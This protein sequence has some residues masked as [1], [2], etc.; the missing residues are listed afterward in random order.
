LILVSLWLAVTPARDAG[1]AA[2]QQ[3]AAAQQGGATQQGGAA[4]PSAATQ[5][6]GTQ[7][8]LQVTL[9]DLSNINPSVQARLRDAHA[10]LMKEL[11]RLPASPV[12]VAN[13]YGEMGK[14]FMATR[15]N[16]EAERC[17]R[18]AQR[19]A[20]R[21]FAWPYYLGH[22]LRNA[23]DL[24]GAV[25]FFEL[26]RQVRPLDFPTLIWLGRLYL[27]QSRPAEAESRLAEALTVRPDHPAVRF[28]MGRVALAKHDYARAVTNLSAALT[29]S[30]ESTV[31]HYQLALAY[32]GLGDL[33]K[34]A[35]HLERRA[36]R[37]SARSTAGLSIPFPDPLLAALNGI[38]QTPQAYRERGLD[39]AAVGNWP[40]ALENYRRAVDADP[41]Y[42][43]MRVNLGTALEQVGDPRGA[44]E[45]YQEALRLDPGLAEGHYGLGHLFE[46]GGRDQEAIDHYR[47]A[48]K[49]NST[50]APAYLRL[51]DA[52]RRTGQLEESLS[53]Y[54]HVI[55]LEPADRDALFGEAMALVRLKQYVDARDRLSE[56]MTIYPD[57]PMFRHALARVLAAAPDDRVRDGER[58]WKLV[59]GRPNEAQHPGA[60]ETMAMVLAELGH[61]DLAVDWQ[62]LAMSAATRAGQP[63][64]SQ[65]MAVNLA[66]YL[67]H[68]PCRTPWRDDDPDHKPGPVV[69]SGLLDKPSPK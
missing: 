2:Q 14:L 43:A 60:F 30:P 50:F 17:F 62:R 67:R 52:L 38:V 46:R 35:Y 61:F 21:E 31:I 39:A 53:E 9:P 27:D 66:L 18:N 3:G 55:A 16:E 20:F 8:L 34:A 23:G 69:D 59:D 45:Q 25:E 24:A 4:Q 54:R 19:L 5:L 13:A 56:A 15:F 7:D 22:V 28:E 63:K 68:Q 49:L 29:A 48:V 36:G 40:V 6:Q 37:G 10:S 11:Q 64:I 1:A 65:Q 12:V 32:R 51:A 58:A 57:Q 41:K 44:L 33:D 47:A 42:A 26:A